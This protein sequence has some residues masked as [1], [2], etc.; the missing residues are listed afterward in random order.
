[1]TTVEFERLKTD[2][3]NKEKELNRNEGTIE[4]L[5]AQLKE[6]FDIDKLQDANTLLTQLE[7]EDAKYTAEITELFS[8]IELVIGGHS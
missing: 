2:V 8:Q 5:R 3:S 7:A 4:T 6:Q 1:M